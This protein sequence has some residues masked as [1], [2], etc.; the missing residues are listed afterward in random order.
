M[1]EVSGIALGEQVRERLPRRLSN[2]ALGR[3]L[4]KLT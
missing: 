4:W 3:D 1:K 2:V